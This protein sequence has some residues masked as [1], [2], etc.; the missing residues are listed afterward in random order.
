MVFTDT[1]LLYYGK[2]LIYDQSKL[3]Y[4]NIYTLY[5]CSNWLLKYKKLQKEQDIKDCQDGVS[6]SLYP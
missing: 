4:G 2:L 3:S 1:D 5:T 6:D